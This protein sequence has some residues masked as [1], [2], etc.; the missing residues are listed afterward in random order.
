MT[1]QA[2][3]QAKDQLEII[4]ELMQRLRVAQD[5]GDEDAEDAAREEIEGLPL[6]VTVRSGW[7]RPGEAMEPEEYQILLCTGGP[8]VRIVGDLDRWGEP[9]NAV[10]EYADWGTP[11][12][13]YPADLGEARALLDFARQ[14]YYGG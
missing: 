10:L 5:A 1:E 6:E 4:V 8:A 9:A 13:A 12:T 7:R 14:F 3:A 2:H 11:W